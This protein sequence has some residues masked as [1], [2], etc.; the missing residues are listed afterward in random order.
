M[1]LD[2]STILS[3]T[4]LPPS[5]DDLPWQAAIKLITAITLLA[6]ALVPHSGKKGDVVSMLTCNDP[7]DTRNHVT[8]SAQL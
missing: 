4:Q 5:G 6:T 8:P 2:L 1:S 7:P 3:P